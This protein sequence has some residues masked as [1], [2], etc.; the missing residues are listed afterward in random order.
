MWLLFKPLCVENTNNLKTKNRKY[1]DSEVIDCLQTGDDSLALE[2]LYVEVFPKIKKYILSNAGSYDDAFDIFQDAVVVLCRQV[3]A[4][5]Y[6]AA[7]EIDG[8]LFFVSRNLW[9]NKAKR[10][11]RKVRMSENFD[12]SDNYD[13]SD[14][15]V[16][17]EKVRGLGVITKLLGEKCLELLKQS[18]VFKASSEEIATEMGFATANAVKTQKYKCKQKL[19]QILEENPKLNELIQ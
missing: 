6:N 13:Y 12:H 9:I 5:K 16:T 17:D 3:H 18:I 14:D 19:L 10:D 2:H 1:S 11:K 7:F 8:F 15:I 4:G